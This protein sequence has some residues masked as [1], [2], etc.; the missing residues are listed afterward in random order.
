V[1]QS[2]L[3]LVAYFWHF[4]R[5]ALAILLDP[6]LKS[7]VAKC[8]GASNGDYNNVDVRGNR[9]QQQQ[10]NTLLVPLSTTSVTTTTNA[11]LKDDDE[12]INDSTAVAL[13]QNSEE[14]DIC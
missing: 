4:T 13:L 1:A 12:K 11:N 10:N 9:Q 7:D 3:W 8:F 6:D 14:S 5:P 2:L